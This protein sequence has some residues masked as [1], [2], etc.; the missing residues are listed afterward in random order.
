MNKVQTI[1]LTLQKLLMKFGE[2]QTDKGILSYVG[3]DLEVGMEVLLGDEIAPDGDYEVADSNMIIRVADGKVAEIVMKEEAPVE[4][5][6]AAEEEAPAE[7]A[8]AE[9]AP[10]EEPAPA[11]PD[12][13]AIILE[14]LSPVTQK[15]ADMEA[16]LEATEARLAEIEAKLLEAQAKPADEIIEEMI[17]DE[18][19]F[20]RSGYGYRK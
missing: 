3:D 12:M 1:K 5:I 15:I 8:P 10:V 19:G 11:E 16:R 9:E 7:E 14:I 13:Q 17:P 20:F 6:E 2:S 18:S 4:E